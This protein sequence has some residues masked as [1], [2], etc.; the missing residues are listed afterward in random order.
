MKLWML[1]S[2]SSGNAVLVQAGGDRILIDAGFGPRTLAG[3]LK[4]AHTKPDAIDACFLTHEHSDHIAGVGKA[5]AKWGWPVFASAGTLRG[6]ELDGLGVK[7]LACGSSVTLANMTV[8]SVRTSHDARESA[9][10]VVTDIR[11][12]VRAAVF[13]DFGYVS[14]AVRAA[15][16]DV[17]V[18]VMESNHDDRML[19][20][21][22]YPPWLQARIASRTGHLSNHAAADFISRSVSRTLSH[23]VLAH[24]SERCNSPRVALETVGTPLRKTRF[25]GRLTAARQD[26]VSEKVS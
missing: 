5:M 15:C 12:G 22:P 26:A 13:Y 23:V 20:A 7:P 3:R 11:S 24:L 16:A 4:V 9:G 2:G 17:D 21:G 19:R 1:G 25:R 6:A 10:Y 18:L 14:A 8:E